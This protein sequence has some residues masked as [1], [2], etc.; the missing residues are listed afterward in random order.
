MATLVSLSGS[1]TDLF[2]NVASSL[3]SDHG[4]SDTPT[5]F[6]SPLSGSAGAGHCCDTTVGGAGPYHPSKIKCLLDAFNILLIKIAECSTIIH[7][8]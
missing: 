2:T 3:K 4:P 7:P 6:T 1:K 5:P 8:R